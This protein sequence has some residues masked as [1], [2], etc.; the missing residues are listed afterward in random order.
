M[1]GRK[2]SMV[3]DEETLRRAREMAEYAG[4]SLSAW[5]A[6][7]TR[8]HVQIEEGLREVDRYEAE[9]GPIPEDALREADEWLDQR[10]IR[11]L[12]P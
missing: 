12:H 5:L 6:R 1:A 2:V 8:Y 7:A 4:L 3:L 10:G 9:F 11:R